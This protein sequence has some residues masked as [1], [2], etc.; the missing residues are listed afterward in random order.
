MRFSNLILGA[1]ILASCG[2]AQDSMQDAVTATMEKAIEENVGVSVDLGDAASFRENA[3]SVDFIVGDKIYL[4]KSNKLVANAIF[5]LE[6]GGLAISFQMANAKGG[7]LI[8]MI[9]HIPRDFSLPLVGKF[10]VSNSYD[11]ENPVASLMY[12]ETGEAGMMM[13]PM[14]YEG[15]LT[16]TK[17]TEE[18]MEF[19]A[20]AKGGEPIDAE[21]PANWKPIQ[22]KG[23][24]KMPIIQSLG[25]DKDD[26]LK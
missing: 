19:E 3:G 22:V 21:N 24:L 8:A 12:M 20:V 16:I 14:P 2:R 9:N 25:I 1:F 10:S 5:M 18:E 4:Q 6:E 13:T 15:T 7:S 17:L 11:G 26:V 23:S